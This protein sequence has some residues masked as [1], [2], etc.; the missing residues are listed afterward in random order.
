MNFGRLGTGRNRNWSGPVR[1]VTGQTGPV[2]TGKV[3]PGHDSGARSSL[4]HSSVAVSFIG[5]LRQVLELA[6]PGME[7]ETAV[8]CGMARLPLIEVAL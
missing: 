5:T 8:V 2:P 1:P 4:P 3:N 7:T 6:L